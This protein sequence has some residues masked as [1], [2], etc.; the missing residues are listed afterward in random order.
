M[1]SIDDEFIILARLLGV[2]MQMALSDVT[3]A[4]DYEIAAEVLE[5]G[6]IEFP[7]DE[8]PMEPAGD[9][10]LFSDLGLDE[11]ELRMICE[12]TDMYPEEQIEI[13]ANRLGFAEELAEMID[14]D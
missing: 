11:M 6:D 8:D 9:L 3:T 1:L 13:I 10:N 7:V 12:D 14:G 5:L 2:N 4:L